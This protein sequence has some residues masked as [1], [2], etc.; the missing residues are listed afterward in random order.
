MTAVARIPAAALAGL[1]FCAA[2]PPSHPADARGRPARLP[3]RRTDPDA[4]DCAATRRQPR[5]FVR[6]WIESRALGAAST[7]MLTAPDYRPSEPPSGP[8]EHALAR[9]LKPYSQR[10]HRL[11]LVYLLGAEQSGRYLLDLRRNDN[12]E[13]L[14]DLCSEL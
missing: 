11:Y 13:W 3:A 8:F 6:M 2:G 4:P 1:A 5:A 14:V 12:Q 9:W 10:G 7:C